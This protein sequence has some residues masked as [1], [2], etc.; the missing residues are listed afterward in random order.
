MA[1]SRYDPREVERFSRAW[2]LA[3]LRSGLWVVVATLLIW[4]YADLEFTDT[5]DFTAT[6][7]LASEGRDDL[8]MRDVDANDP[9]EL[10]G[11]DLAAVEVTFRARGSRG[12]INLAKEKLAK[13]GG[14]IRY[15]L[16]Q[17]ATP[18][19]VGVHNL[20]LQELLNASDPI[21]S[22]GLTVV[23][24]SRPNARTLPLALDRAIR[25]P[26][27][28]VVFQWTGADLERWQ[29]FPARVD[30]TIAEGYWR[31]VQAEAPRPQ[32]YTERVDLQNA[33][34]EPNTPVTVSIEPRIGREGYPVR[35][36]Q[37]DVL[38]EYRFSEQT[39]EATL[40]VPVRLLIPHTWAED[41]T[42]QQYIL[43]K[44]DPAAWLVS[45]QI[46]G[47][48]KD[49][50]RLKPEDVDAYVVLAEQD[51]RWLESWDTKAIQVHFAAG[52]ESLQLV[53]QPAPLSLKLEPRPAGGTPP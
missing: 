52:Y 15:D 37:P 34:G 33:P 21:A 41:N 20:N 44:R 29:A 13:Q 5:A 14:I 51:K 42:W 30:L 11:T 49:L 9:L 53:N 45:L 18:Y 2:W 26:G 23:S 25:V 19:Q 48:R 28:E 8:A 46:R 7:M 31:K 3:G 1:R 6:L 40:K 47:P 12:A 35:L 4:V 17:A 27:I 24:V 38:V 22:A 39:S 10:R 50:E 16:T 36:S 32:L 43:R